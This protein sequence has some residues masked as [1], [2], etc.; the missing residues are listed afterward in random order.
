MLQWV[1]ADAVL[2]A[3]QTLCRDKGNGHWCR[4]SVDIFSKS[5]VST[6]RQ[7]FS[8]KVGKERQSSGPRKKL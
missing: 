2:G 6:L 5:L 4:K 1:R 7:Q 8:A 3:V